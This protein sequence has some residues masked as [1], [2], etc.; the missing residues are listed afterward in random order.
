MNKRSQTQQIFVYILMVIIVGVVFIF[1]FRAISQI[2][3]KGEDV[4]LAK[5]KNDLTDMVRDI[6]ASH[7]IKREDFALSSR[8][9]RIC[10]ASTSPLPETK[11]INPVIRSIV[12]SGG[13]ENTFLLS[14]KLEESFNVGKIYLDEGYLCVDSRAGKIR[15][16][17]E[18]MGN[19]TAIREW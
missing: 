14:D 6:G 5:F 17:F 3:Q 8:F 12:D 11:K 15:L 13:L 9:S 10:F 4:A 2:M 1:G 19:S 16:Q 7:D 18:G